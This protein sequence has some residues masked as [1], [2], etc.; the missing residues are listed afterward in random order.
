LLLLFDAQRVNFSTFCDLVQFGLTNSDEAGEVSPRRGGT[1]HQRVQCLSSDADYTSSS[2]QSCDTVIYVGK[3]GRALSDRELTD[4]EGPPPCKPR[5]PSATVVASTPSH[6]SVATS[7]IKVSEAFVSSGG[8]TAPVFAVSTSAPVNLVA[9]N[10]DV[11]PSVED[12]SSYVRVM[13]SRRSELTSIGGDVVNCTNE[14]TKLRKTAAG[15]RGA[16]PSTVDGAKERWIDGPRSILRFSDVE[17]ASVAAVIDEDNADDSAE[18]WVD[19]PTEFQKDPNSLVESLR[20]PMKLRKSKCAKLYRAR[21]AAVAAAATA[22][23]DVGREE[24]T[25]LSRDYGE[26]ARKSVDATDLVG[27]TTATSVR[28]LGADTHHR[29]SALVCHGR[30]LATTAPDLASSNVEELSR[31]RGQRRSSGRKQ[32]N[33]TKHTTLASF[34]SPNRCPPSAQSSPGRRLRPAGAQTPTAIKVGVRCGDRTAQ[35]VRSVQV[36]TAA[37]G[38]GPPA[39]IATQFA[40]RPMSPLKS[41]SVDRVLRGYGADVFSGLRAWHDDSASDDAVTAVS[42]NSPPPDYATCVAADLDRRRRHSR[43]LSSPTANLDINENLAA[44]GAF[45]LVS[46]QHPVSFTPAHIAAWSLPCSCSVAPGTSVEAANSRTFASGNQQPETIFDSSTWPRRQDGGS[47]SFAAV[48]DIDSELT[49]SPCKRLHHPDGASNPQLSEEVS[50]SELTDPDDCCKLL[51]LANGDINSSITL[52]TSIPT[53]FPV[54]N[55]FHQCDP[56]LLT[57]RNSIHSVKGSDEMQPA[58]SPNGIP[59]LANGEPINESVL[60]TAALSTTKRDRHSVVPPT[61]KSSKNASPSTHLKAPSSPVKTAPSKRNKSS[62]SSGM[63][64]LWCIHPRCGKSRSS[65]SNDESTNPDRESA[66][67]GVDR[68]QQQA[69]VRMRQLSNED[70]ARVRDSDH[71]S[72]LGECTSQTAVE[73]VRRLCNDDASCEWSSKTSADHLPSDSNPVCTNSQT[74]GNLHIALSL[75]LHYN[76]TSIIID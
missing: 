68:Q 42:N 76:F 21:A 73:L 33:Q 47:L 44:A 69:P 9:G 75:Q 56:D 15:R 60:Q 36:A 20:S 1:Q 35:W 22:V 71:G 31:S 3:N 13:D 8:N 30:L 70:F 7:S 32:T 26:T 2:E 53:S 51:T 64:L 41:H 46:K 52:S 23:D 14:A 10:H 16:P 45:G 58:L 66:A 59:L 25:Q 54:S 29:D 67:D 39:A 72:L 37:A 65:K 19:G 17:G 4:N 50:R 74:E 34:Y 61:P 49:S 63:S 48:D 24:T 57:Y 62:S 11:H 12:S 55:T 28:Q 38:V 43:R 18:M 27:T 40:A 5:T 6:R